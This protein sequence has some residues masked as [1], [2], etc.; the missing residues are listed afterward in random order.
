MTVPKKQLEAGVQASL[1][2]ADSSLQAG[3]AQAEINTATG[4]AGYLTTGTAG[5]TVTG[6][7]IVSTITAGG[8]GI[9]TE[10]AVLNRIIEAVTNLRQDYYWLNTAS[11]I[12]AY[13]NTS[14]VAQT[15]AEITFTLVHNA[16]GAVLHSSH[17]SP[18][19]YPTGLT[20]Q[21]G[22]YENHCHAARTLGNRGCTMYWTL[23]EYKADTS[24]VVIGTSQSS[25]AITSKAPVSLHLHLAAD[26]TLT[27]GSRVVSKKYITFAGGEAATTV[28]LY[29]AS[30]YDSHFGVLQ[31]STVLG[32]A[33]FAATT[34]FATAAQGATADGAVQSPA[35]KW[36]IT[37]GRLVHDGTRW[38]TGISD[39]LTD[40]ALDADIWTETWGGTEPTTHAEGANG[41]VVTTAAAAG[42]AMLSTP[43]P[44]TTCKI[45]ANLACETPTG[46]GSDGYGLPINIF[47]DA[48][49]YFGMQAFR[50][51]ANYSV[52][53]QTMIAGAYTPIGQAVVAHP[54]WLML[55]L[56][57]HNFTVY[58]NPA[59][60]STTVPVAGW[61]LVGGA[62]L[63]WLP[64]VPP[65]GGAPFI[66]VRTE[67]YSTTPIGTTRAR[68]IRIIP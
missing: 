58:R 63:P 62:A 52:K 65:V 27:A 23:V 33:A 47:L 32:S 41:Y 59:A 5:A 1:D 46:A 4:G 55:V 38:L 26:Y 19:G 68:H 10:E 51:G 39:D 12:G 20:L 49:N 43:L 16:D 25:G 18:V 64:T 7:A 42:W 14:L 8:S 28:V 57:Y 61:V 60:P 54:T 35:G 40:S 22:A 30:T 13:Y 56:G 29:G 37:G 6:T 45:I 24:E 11:G 34:D 50:E 9:P 17:I 15:G 67:T 48:T 21:A 66:G 44:A 31:E 2:K 36:A 3:D 53:A